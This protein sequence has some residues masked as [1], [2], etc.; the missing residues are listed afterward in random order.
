VVNNEI[1]IL[2]GIHPGLVLDKKL[3]EHKLKKGRF[4]ISIDEYPQTL[5]AITKGTRDM[6]LTLALKIEEA[7]GLE[8]G[9]FMLLQ[10]YYNIKKEKLKREH[11]KPDLSKFRKALFWDTDITQIDWERQSK[12]IIRRIFERGN[13]QEK[14]EIIRFYG[15]AKIDDALAGV[16]SK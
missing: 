7:L 5:T 9:Y 6:N 11:L 10:L 3:K 2:K 15:S 16:P 1:T 12:A 14:A 13:R 4:A 8:E